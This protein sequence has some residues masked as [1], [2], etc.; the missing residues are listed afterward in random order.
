MSISQSPT[1][2]QK[3]SNFSSALKRYFD[4]DEEMV[5]NLKYF[6]PDGNHISIYKIKP[7]SCRK[8]VKKENIIHKINEKYHE[9]AQKHLGRELDI[10]K[11]AEESKNEKEMR[12]LQERINELKS[13]KKR[14]YSY[15][16][17]IQIKKEKNLRKIEIL[18]NVNFCKF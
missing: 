8:E 18:E 5:K 4:T 12:Y 13:E 15:L 17:D 14:N 6:D 11:Q 9:Q 16:N 2:L 10:I 3:K 7:L 1:S